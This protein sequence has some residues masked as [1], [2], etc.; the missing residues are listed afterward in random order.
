[1]YQDTE[2][3]SNTE[4]VVST[5]NWLVAP[6]IGRVIPFGYAIDPND[7][8]LLLPIP[9]ELEALERAKRHL[10][11]YSYREVAKWIEEVTGRYISHIGLRKRVENDRKSR[12]ALKGYKLQAKRLEKIIAKLEKAES[13]NNPED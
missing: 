2:E 13:I 5:K 9:L 8:D 3:M 12:G 10:R 1:M 7:E 6:R 11:N 4:V